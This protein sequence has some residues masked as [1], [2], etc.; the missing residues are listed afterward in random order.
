MSICTLVD[1]GAKLDMQAMLGDWPLDNKI[2]LVGGH[3]GAG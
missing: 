2:P 1:E 3:E